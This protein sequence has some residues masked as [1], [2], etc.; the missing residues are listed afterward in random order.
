MEESQARGTWQRSS[1]VE[2][3]EMPALIEFG[4]QKNGA[5]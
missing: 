1:K 5:I 3:N 2:E 4:Q